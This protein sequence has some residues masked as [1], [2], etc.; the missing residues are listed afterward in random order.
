MKNKKVLATFR[1]NKKRF[2]DFKMRVIENGS[3]NMETIDIILKKFL[4]KPYLVEKYVPSKTDVIVGLYVD[5]D[6]KRRLKKWCIDNNVTQQD[7]FPTYIEKY[8]NKN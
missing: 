7:V 6:M 5:K 4:E 2:I 1:I 8:L 3:N